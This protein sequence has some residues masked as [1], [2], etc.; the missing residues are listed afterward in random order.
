MRMMILRRGWI[1]GEHVF[2]FPT[3]RHGAIFIPATTTTT[4]TTTLHGMA[5][6]VCL[7]GRQVA[8]QWAKQNKPKRDTLS[9]ILTLHL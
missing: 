8:D 4:T 9:A 1:R 6:L 7:D 3:N 5:L 2:M